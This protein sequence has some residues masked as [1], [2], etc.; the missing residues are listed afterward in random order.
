MKN[1][2]KILWRTIGLSTLG[3]VTAGWLIHLLFPVPAIAI[4]IDRSYCPATQWAQVVQQYDKLYQQQ[5]RGNLQIQAV[6]LFSSLG[7]DINTVAPTP[8]A[9]KTMS[10][11]GPTIP[12][13]QRQQIQQQ[14]E[15]RYGRSHLLTC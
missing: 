13:P 8:S 3:F 14:I 1:L 7:Q 9:L 6:V 4:L 10:T 12:L 5:Q 11:Y 2:N 15:G